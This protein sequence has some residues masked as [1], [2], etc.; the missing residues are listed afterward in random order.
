ML[1]CLITVGNFSAPG[2]KTIL[3]SLCTYQE[4]LSFEG[5]C[6]PVLQSRKHLLRRLM[7]H[8]L[9]MN[10]KDCGYALRNL[11]NCSKKLYGKKS[12]PWL[13]MYYFFCVTP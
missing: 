5:L 12:D 10:H 13:G 9:D 4:G 3:C 6:A 8:M 7:N 11:N 2:T 1:G